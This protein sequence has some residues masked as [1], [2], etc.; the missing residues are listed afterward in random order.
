ML[1]EIKKLKGKQNA[2]VCKNRS[3]KETEFFP[4]VDAVQKPHD[5]QSLTGLSLRVTLD[6]PTTSKPKLEPN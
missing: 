4:T 6:S 5:S 3:P 2:K 1:K